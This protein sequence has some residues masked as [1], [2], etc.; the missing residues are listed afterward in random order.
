MTTDYIKDRHNLD[1][2]TVFSL[3]SA[4]TALSG[5]QGYSLTCKILPPLHVSWDDVKVR[6]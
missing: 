6:Q 3:I 4:A 2:Y 5:H 1:S